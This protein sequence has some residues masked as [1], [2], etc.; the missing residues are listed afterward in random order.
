LSEGDFEAV[1]GEGE[2][3]G[4]QRCAV[5]PMQTDQVIDDGEQ[6]QRRVDRLLPGVDVGDS[7]GRPGS[8]VGGCVHHRENGVEGEAFV[9]VGL[10]AGEV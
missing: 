4:D 7:P 1:E 10:A 3:R 6:Q 8:A 9:E 5:N 2:G